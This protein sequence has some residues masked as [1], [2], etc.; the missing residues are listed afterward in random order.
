VTQEAPA[1]PGLEQVVEVL[2]GAVGVARVGEV[3]GAVLRDVEVVR[4]TEGAAARLSGEDCDPALAID[5]EQALLRIAYDEAA[6]GIEA[7]AQRPPARVREVLHRPL[8]S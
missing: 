2:L 4:E 6:L 1:G 7:E 8:S 5:R 3:D